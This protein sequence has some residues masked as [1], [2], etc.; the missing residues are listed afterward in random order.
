V[1]SL[2]SIVHHSDII[3]AMD[4]LERLHLGNRI[5]C[6]QLTLSKLPISITHLTL[7][8]ARILPSMRDRCFGHLV[9][10]VDLTLTI[11]YTWEQLYLPTSLTRLQVTVQYRA[12]FFPL[13]P[14]TIPSFLLFIGTI[15]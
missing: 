12:H 11:F 13:S 5:W 7:S 10:L 4:G 14:S 8:D 15:N 1:S 9:H 2:S 3:G 6:D